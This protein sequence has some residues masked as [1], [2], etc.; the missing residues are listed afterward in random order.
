MTTHCGRLLPIAIIA[1]ALA[2]WAT[3][4]AAAGTDRNST[5][6][7]W[8]PEDNPHII[9]ATLSFGPDTLLKIRPGTEVRLYPAVSLNFNGGRLEAIGT[10][11]EKITFTRHLTN[12][13]GAIY[14]NGSQDNRISH[15]IIEHGSRAAPTQRWAMVE[16]HDEADLEMDHCEL[17]Y[18]TYSGFIAQFSSTF[19]IHDCVVHDGDERGLTSFNMSTGSFENCEVYNTAYDGIEVD[20]GYQ[21][22]NVS[23]VDNIVHNIG[24]DGIDLDWWYSGLV[25]RNTI[26]ACDDK[27]ISASAYCTTLCANNVMYDC[28]IGVAI[29]AGSYADIVNCTLYDID[30]GV[31]SYMKT[32]FPGSDV[33]MKNTIIW[34]THEYALNADTASTITTTYC[35]IDEVVPGEGNISSDPLF[36]NAAGANFHILSDSPCIDS[37]T[38]DSPAPSADYEGDARIDD[39]GVPNTGGGTYPYYDIGAD[40]RNE[41][42]TGVVVLPPPDPR[43][44]LRTSPNPASTGTGIEL[45]L[46]RPTS[47]IVELFDPAGRRVRRL[48][49]GRLTAGLHR[50]HWDGRD[51]GG[52][53]SAP[54][55]YFIRAAGPEGAISTNVVL[56]GR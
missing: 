4:G 22:A 50:M 23:I 36:V 29:S 16:I 25:A 40:E 44:L 17:Q 52:R 10:Q 5:I 7:E 41:D 43:F 24:D 21:G 42:A 56:S 54:G 15:A 37:G 20:G 2:L 14:F 3:P 8:G 47:L 53:L 31:R 26:F 28:Y 51:D 49:Q 11:A 19:Y 34:G 30:R 6:I 1:A 32:D 35:D 39:E 48:H 38:S 18:F 46:E 55:V 33:V 9:A 13:W 27:G 45:R 12:K